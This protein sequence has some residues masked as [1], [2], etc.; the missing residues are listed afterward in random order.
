MTTRLEEQIRRYT[1][2]VDNMA[3]PVED[4]LPHGIVGKLNIETTDL[5]ITIPLRPYPPAPRLAGWLKVAAAIVVAGV[6]AVPIWVLV[7]NSVPDVADTPKTTVAPPA[8]TSTTSTTS[9]TLPTGVV[10]SPV[11]GHLYE[12]VSAGGSISWDLARARAQQRSIGGV[13]GHLATFTSEDEYLFVVE[14]LPDAFIA[15]EGRNPFW[16][17]GFQ[18]GLNREEPGGG[19]QWVTGEP[20]VY[21]AWDAGEPN[22]SNE[23]EDCLQPHHT[24]VNPEFPGWNDQP[25]GDTWVQGYIVEYDTNP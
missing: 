17:G 21:T 7:G 1:A 6:L 15:F 19:W 13:S 16:I 9:T 22:H 8:T 14:A 3:P 4:L 20:W 18:S 5:E 23:R 10:R 25:C 24:P 12:A 11:N 2:A